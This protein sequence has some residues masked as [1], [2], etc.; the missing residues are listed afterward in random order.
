[1]GSDLD[2]TSLISTH[3]FSQ[4]Y[5]LYWDLT[6]KL[7]TYNTLHGAKPQVPI[8][9]LPSCQAHCISHWSY[10]WSGDIQKPAATREHLH[11]INVFQHQD[12]VFQAST[13][14]CRSRMWKNCIEKI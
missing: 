3:F 1:V 12:F 13:V 5:S 11:V 10:C 6:Q 2:Q 14:L 9:S 8:T 4:G 7:P